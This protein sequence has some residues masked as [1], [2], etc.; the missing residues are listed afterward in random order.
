MARFPRRQPPLPP[1]PA[2]PNDLPCERTLAISPDAPADLPAQDLCSDT[3]HQEIPFEHDV[4]HPE[5]IG[6]ERS[7]L[8][9]MDNPPVAGRTFDQL[10]K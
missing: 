3:A 7:R 1:V 5:E 4:G 2:P 8:E 9:M 10:M 6:I